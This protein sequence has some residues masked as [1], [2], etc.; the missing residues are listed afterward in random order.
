[1][2]ASNGFWVLGIITLLSVTVVNCDDDDDDGD[3]L[4]PDGVYDYCKHLSV[5][6]ERFYIAP[7]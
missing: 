3:D 1:M 7:I 2:K 5:L 6:K 4:A